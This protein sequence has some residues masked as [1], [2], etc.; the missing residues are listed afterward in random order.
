M[1]APTDFPVLPGMTAT[2]AIDFSAV[3]NIAAVHWIPAR[4]VVAESELKA[5]VW[6]LDPNS[7]TVSSRRVEIGRM[8]GSNIEIKSGLSGGEEL[9]SVG[10]SYLAEGM[11]VSRMLQSEQAIPRADD[12][13]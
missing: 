4:A 9:I 1:A 12:P 5:L 6:I 13:V 10:A 2:V 3:M 11:K 7:M 8:S